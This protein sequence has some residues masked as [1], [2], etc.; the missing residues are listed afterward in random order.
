MRIRQLIA[1]THR[2]G[3]VLGLVAA[4]ASVSA[5]AT[6]AT[7]SAHTLRHHEAESHSVDITATGFR[8]GIN[9]HGGVEAGLVD[10]RFRNRGHDDHQAQLFRLNKGVTQA[11]FKADLSSGNPAAFLADSVP[12][13][14]AAVTRPRDDQPVWDALQG[15]TYAVVCFVAG[16]DGVPHFLKG[17]IGFFDVHGLVK[18]AKLARLHPHQEVEEEVIKAHDLTYTMPKKLSKNSIY[19]FEDT[20]AADF[21]EINL[22]R[23]KPGKTVADAKAYFAKLAHPGNP[24]P[25]PF[26]SE[27]GHGAVVPNGGHGFFRVDDDPGKYVAF[28][29]VPDDKSGIPHAAEGMVVGVVVR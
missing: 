14:G 10:I 19:R 24:G 7:A 21:H 8:F 1:G 6:P 28:C 2:A 11:K 25:A 20:D 15:G 22:G 5:I 13:G 29:L 9:T 16:P 26:W 27:G 3:T 18:P 4:V 23:L 12:A 17:M